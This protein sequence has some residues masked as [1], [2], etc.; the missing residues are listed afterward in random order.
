MSIL[1]HESVT[2]AILR[3]S[4]TF[5]LISTSFRCRLELY[6]FIKFS[7]FCI[8]VDVIHVFTSF[9]P[10]ISALALSFARTLL[11]EPDV[12]LSPPGFYVL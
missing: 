5:K 6:M 1:Y 9:L 12:V 11:S 3:V 8:H 7:V 2:V 4:N 10:S